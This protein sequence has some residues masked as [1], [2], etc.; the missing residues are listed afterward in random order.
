[1]KPQDSKSNTQSLP[2]TQE[3]ARASGSLENLSTDLEERS[4][5][6]EIPFS[7]E[8][9]KDIITKL[10][11]DI[12]D[13]NWVKGDYASIDLKLMP[14]LVAQANYKYP[15]LNL[16]FA[17]TFEDLISSLKEAQDKGISSSRYIVHKKD[18]GIHFAVMDHQTIDEK[19]SLILFEPATLNSM[20][21]AML[22]LRTEMAVKSELPGCYFSIA[23][24]D[25]QRSSSECGMFSLALAKKLHTNADKLTRIHQDNIN[26]VLCKQGAPL[27]SE[28]LDTYLPAGFYKHTQGSRRLDQYMKSNPGSESE[29]V[30]KQE[31]TLR[32]RFDKNSIKTEDDKTVSVSSHRKR[33]R[34][35][36]SL[37]L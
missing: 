8:Q 21:T 13:G 9:L 12:A 36:N 22:A 10:E 30:N 35:Y 31:Q 1:M 26:G 16:K 37:M 23:E 6:A 4:F 14:A 11:R 17:E 18:G 15:Q 2:S 25:I 28:K 33:V 34:E 24:M 29:K 19:M 5:D 27:P 32:E 7:Q 3:G 20:N